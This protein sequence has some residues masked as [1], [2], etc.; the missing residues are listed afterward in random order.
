VALIMDVDLHNEYQHDENQHI[1]TH[2]DCRPDGYPLRLGWALGFDLGL[3][4]SFG[5]SFG[6]RAL[7]CFDRGASPIGH[8]VG[9]LE[10]LGW[11]RVVLHRARL[12]GERL[13]GPLPEC[14]E[15]RARGVVD[16][17]EEGV[18]NQSEDDSIAV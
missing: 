10:E 12:V 7:A 1:C 16:F 15:S 2:V 18:G 8:D 17:Q 5:F 6:G 4:L 13:K 11:R 14:F 3:W 9:I